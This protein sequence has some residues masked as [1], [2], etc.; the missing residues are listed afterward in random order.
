MADDAN[1]SVLD[2]QPDGEVPSAFSDAPVTAS[3]RAANVAP[4][5][6]IPAFNN[7]LSVPA[8]TSLQPG[9]TPALRD[10]FLKKQ[11]AAHSA[12]MAQPGEELGNYTPLQTFAANGDQAG[13]GPYLS[14]GRSKLIGSPKPYG[15]LVSD[16]QLREARMR[17]IGSQQNPRS[18]WAGWG[19]G[20]VPAVLAGEGKGAL[21]GLSA[22][23]GLTRGQG[24]PELMK[25]G[26]TSGKAWGDIA[27][28]TGMGA[29]EGR[30]GEYLG[31]LYRPI[32]NEATRAA[33]A[34]GV[35]LPRAY[36]TGTSALKNTGDQ[37]ASLFKTHYYGG[38]DAAGSAHPGVTPDGLVNRA[39]DVFMSAPAK[40]GNNL[41]QAERASY[42]WVSRNLPKY[43]DVF[44]AI[45]HMPAQVM[46]G[47]TSVLEDYSPQHLV[48]LQHGF[49]ASHLKPSVGGEMHVPLGGPSG[50]VRRFESMASGTRDTLLHN[51]PDLQ[52]L[53]NGAYTIGSSTAEKAKNAY[54][55]LI[56]TGGNLIDNA[57][58][59][60]ASAVSNAG[61]G[62]VNTAIKY[63]APLY[64]IAKGI[65]SAPA[66]AAVEGAALGNRYVVQP[67]VRAASSAMR[68]R[69]VVPPSGSTV[70][71]YIRPS[72]DALR[73]GNLTNVGH[74]V[75]NYAHDAGHSLGGDWWHKNA[76]HFLGGDHADGGRVAYKSGGKVGADIEPLVQNLMRSYKRAKTDET[77]NTK[78]LLQHSDK[79][80]VRALHIAKKAF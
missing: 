62:M 58:V 59:P 10:Y 68:N 37:I 74:N 63:G 42:N 26:P 46:D 23:Q 17:T 18:S 60:T 65:V 11:A 45:H 55:Q 38:L 25:Y 80:I 32:Q 34:L 78:P 1:R 21:T 54:G 7:P 48:D 43:G 2:D 28:D 8:K 76:P 72:I 16:D 70:M 71:S 19:L 77:V 41:T 73:Q 14:A 12:F 53:M 22:A 27:A 52:K 64:A 51:R 50:L 79:T 69:N 44:D 6:V 40:M 3:G 61:S 36:A 49:V 33:Q 20:M 13:L 4:P 9:M 66:V 29:I 31:G 75:E 47:I 56:N 15:E 5:P 24:L 57:Y 67:A 30:A 35:A 39:L